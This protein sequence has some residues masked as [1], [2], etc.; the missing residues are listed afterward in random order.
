MER[1][2]GALSWSAVMERRAADMRRGADVPAA[3]HSGP[4]CAARSCDGEG[5][6]VTEAMMVAMMAAVM[7]LTT[8][9]MQQGR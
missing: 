5:D 8:I 7:T 2:H 3:R 9:L 1:C 6:A 4:W